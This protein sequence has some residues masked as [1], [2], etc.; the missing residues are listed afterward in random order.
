MNITTGAAAITA[1]SRGPDPTR[2]RRAE[3]DAHRPWHRVY[4]CLAGEVFE[5]AVRGSDREEAMREAE[6]NWCTDTPHTP[7]TW[8]LYC[9]LDDDQ[10][11]P[12]SP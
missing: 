11:A 2:A 7:A 1:A 4:V 5:D 10:D 8:I 3:R 6:A 9:G 12:A